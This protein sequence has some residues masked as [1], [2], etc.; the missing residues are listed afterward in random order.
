MR[1][2]SSP[3][4]I[5]NCAP[6]ATPLADVTYYLM[7]W[8]TQPEGRSGVMGLTGAGSGIP[9]LEA[10]VERYCARTHRDG[11][12]DLDWYFAFNLFRL[13]GIV[14]GIKKR[15]LIGTASS[16]QAEATAARVPMLADAAWAFARRAGAPA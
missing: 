14:Q 2:A 7:S 9:T 5:G 15:F 3:C 13:A 16:T 4:W 11:L 10:M 1:G 12:P 6:W 8:V